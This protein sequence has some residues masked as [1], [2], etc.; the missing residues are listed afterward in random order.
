MRKTLNCPNSL[1]IV[2]EKE[3][4]N[5]KNMKLKIVV[6]MLVMTSALMLATFNGPSPVV[7][8]RPALPSPSG[9]F[10]KYGPRV[11]MLIF[12]VS[13]STVR[14]YDDFEAGLTDLMFSSAPAEKWETW[15][16]DPDVVMGELEEFAPIY[17]ALNNMRWPLGHGDQ[18]PKDWPG[19]PTGYISNHSL[20][21]WNGD[22]ASS[23]HPVGTADKT[24]IDYDCQRCID[25]RWFRRGLAHM[26][27]RA[28]QI[29][30]MA[31]AAIP[32]D[33]SL[34]FPLLKGWELPNVTEVY[35]QAGYLTRYAYS[36]VKARD[37]FL[38]GGFKDWDNDNK[39]EYSPGHNGAVVEEL[40][41][42]EF[43]T[44]V[45]D[46]H[47]THLGQMITAD[48]LLLGIPHVLYIA[49]Y[50]TVATNVWALYDYDIYTEYWGWAPQPDY[51]AEWFASK[52]DI[53]PDPWGNNE[54]RY[55]SQ[56]FDYWADLFT[57]A[58]SPAAAKSSCYRM[59][60]IIHRDVP[61]IPCYIYVGYHP[62]K[63]TYGTWPGDEKYAGRAWEGMCN[64]GG[65]GF[66]SSV[67]WTYTNVHPQGFEKGG[68]LRQGLRIDAANLD[69]I[70]TWYSYDWMILNE[71]YDYLTRSNP[72]D[73]SKYEPWLCES[74]EVGTWQSANGPCS[75]VNFTLIPGILWQDGVP[76]T[77]EDIEF[78]FWF[79]RECRSV[80]Y[81]Y[82][83]DYNSSVI[84]ENT[85]PGK[86][87]IEIRFNVLSWL[88]LYWCNGN[89]IIPEHIWSDQ[90][91]R[92]CTAHNA[93]EYGPGV[94]GSPAYV[95]EDHDALIG[96]GPFRFYKDKV[97]GRVNRVPGEY[98]Y[99][100]PN[101]LYFR[102][103]IWPDVCNADG[104]LPSDGQ[105]TGMDFAVV[106]YPINIFVR[107]N[108]DGTWPPGT[109][110][111][112]CDVN[113]DG[114]IGVG[115]LM[116]IGVNYGDPW[117]PAY[118]EWSPGYPPP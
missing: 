86:E 96:N 45:D 118:Y 52:M 51:Y 28:A 57:L 24:Y 20:S 85:P 71:I 44:R 61:A 35:D 59:Q 7:S 49:T 62:H 92:Y 48:M 76:L 77:A 5:G 12:H 97:V 67:G 90:E 109:W 46:E 15:L 19:Y 4:E 106:A 39:M 107:E 26:V 23:D 13:G 34:L 78:S 60:E 40:P 32:L 53:Y 114:K 88:A 94:L 80:G 29:A 9:P 115:D 11:N 54:H 56:E 17:L 105:V 37:C 93:W 21:L 111:E 95:P 73:R 64:Y 63:R 84:Y 99:L 91:Q 50:G 55:H 3:K 79:T 42:L 98:L 27:D 2:A 33:P 58:G 36:L 72:W 6:L 102:K 89:T 30:F 87:T 66:S 69:V 10:E 110:G 117:P 47:R 101:P 74:Y 68:T 22:P 25:S 38:A 65:E 70:D 31:G 43:Y 108:P 100:E 1:N 81:T 16:D 104:E 113:K 112:P 116:E 103:Y 18:L 14:E 8:V 75:A 83:K 41:A 82:V